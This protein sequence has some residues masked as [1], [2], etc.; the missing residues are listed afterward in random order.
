MKHLDDI[1]QTNIEIIKGIKEHLDVVNLNFLEA[2]MTIQKRRNP[3]RSDRSD[4]PSEY[5]YNEI[6]F[7]SYENRLLGYNME[8]LNM[9]QRDM[10]IYDLCDHYEESI[11]KCRN[12][13]LNSYN[14]NDHISTLIGLHCL[15]NVWDEELTSEEQ[16]KAQ[17]S[18][19]F[20][21]EKQ[22]NFSISS[23][24]DF[25]VKIRNLTF[26]CEIVRWEEIKLK[27]VNSVFGECVTYYDNCSCI[28]QEKTIDI[29]FEIKWM[30]TSWVVS[31]IADGFF[32]NCKDAESIILPGDLRSFNWS[33]WNCPKLKEIKTKSRSIHEKNISNSRGK[34][35]YSHD[36]VLFRILGEIGDSECELI[37][38]P[39]MHSKNYQI[40]TE[41]YC[42][43]LRKVVGISHFAFKDCNN[44]ETLHIPQSVKYIKCNA[45][46]RCNN[47][48]IIYYYGYSKD[49][50]VEGFYGKYGS[51]NPIW[52]C[53]TNIPAFKPEVKI[54][55]SDEEN[56]NGILKFSIGGV[57][58]NMIRFSKINK[59]DCYIG[60]TAVTRALWKIVMM[61][62]PNDQ[63]NDKHAISV[64]YLE[65]QNFIKKINYLTQMQFELPW[66]C[67]WIKAATGGEDGINFNDIKILPSH[68]TYPVRSIRT[69]KLGLYDMFGPGEL[70]KKMNDLYDHHIPLMGHELLG[71]VEPKIGIA[72]REEKYYF[73]L[74]LECDDSNWRNNKHFKSDE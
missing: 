51:V 28:T 3:C 44:I 56:K 42:E 17:E 30:A 55:F 24:R 74:Y 2:H 18:L 69:N 39:N 37:A 31:D 29:P 13:A 27:K 38:F 10:Y 70:C 32:D 40:P 7:D 1:I 5:E 66:P 25:D 4:P 14:R 34:Y 23:L 72:G 22:L 61:D 35:C 57:E 60:E 67:S 43:H 21:L 64:N 62:Y 59:N 73:R 58:F 45:F 6:V 46:Y 65:I 63:K 49:L 68:K 12:D 52:L 16:M 48:R 71:K 8:F 11:D 20:E 36:G 41:I 50:K 26:F 19:I 9:T 54:S 47:L 33:F 53:K 15:K